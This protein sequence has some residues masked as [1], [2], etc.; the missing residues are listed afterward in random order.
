MTP[1]IRFVLGQWPKPG[2]LSCREHEAVHTGGTDGI[3]IDSPIGDINDKI[4]FIDPLPT[5]QE[6]VP[7]DEIVCAGHQLNELLGGLIYSDD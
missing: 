6:H 5:I 2:S 4:P 1:I 7:D 3:R